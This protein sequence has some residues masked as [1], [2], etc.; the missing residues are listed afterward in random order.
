MPKTNLF[1]YLQNHE[2]NKSSYKCPETRLLIPIFLTSN[3]LPFS[4]GN[5][6]RNSSGFFL[7]NGGQSRRSQFKYKKKK[8]HSLVIQL[9]FTGMNNLFIPLFLLDS[10]CLQ[11][12]FCYTK[13]GFGWNSIV[14]P[15][16]EDICH[17][18]DRTFFLVTVF[19]PFERESAY[20]TCILSPEFR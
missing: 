2:V 15:G 18:N 14:K 4:L 6:T 9:L 16:P 10:P 11:I 13:R 8:L 3:L 20:T 17:F 1:W 12:S 5:N 7:Q 19:S